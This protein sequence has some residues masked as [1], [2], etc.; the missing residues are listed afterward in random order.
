[1]VGERLEREGKHVYLEL[2]PVVVQQKLTHCKAIILQ[3]KI[4]IFILGWEEML[5]WLTSAFQIKGKLL[6]LNI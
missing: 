3:T 5:F 4:C 2:I 1:M 6:K